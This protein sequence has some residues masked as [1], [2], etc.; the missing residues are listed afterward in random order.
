MLW[1]LQ[2]REASYSSLC[3]F[4][5]MFGA[6]TYYV[7]FN[8]VEYDEPTYYGPF[9]SLE[10]AEDYADSANTGLALAG[11]P[12]SVASYGVVWLQGGITPPLLIRGCAYSH[13]ALYYGDSREPLTHSAPSLQWLSQPR[14]SAP[15]P[16]TAQQSDP[17]TPLRPPTSSAFPRPTRFTRPKG[18]P[19]YTPPASA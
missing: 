17:T 16:S 3:S 19:N 18:S 6:M 13:S 5:Q 2:Q 9:Y 8:T 11:V 7:I 1:L 15:R 10:D 14:N 4:Y 12:G